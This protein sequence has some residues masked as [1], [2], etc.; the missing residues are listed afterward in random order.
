MKLNGKEKFLRTRI[1][2]KKTQLVTENNEG[3]N[4]FF[5]MRAST[6]NA[7]GNNIYLLFLKIINDDNKKEWDFKLIKGTVS[8]EKTKNIQIAWSKAKCTKLELNGK[9][10]KLDE[11]I[12]SLSLTDKFVFLTDNNK[13]VFVL[14][15]R[16]KKTKDTD[17]VINVTVFLQF[18]EAGEELKL[19]HV[20]SFTGWY[21]LF[22]LGGK[23]FK[24]PTDEPTANSEE[25]AVFNDGE[26]K[27]TKSDS[28]I[29][30]LWSFFKDKST[31]V[32]T[33]IGE[34]NNVLLFTQEKQE[35]TGKKKSF[36]FVD[37]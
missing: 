3:K 14:R 21:S 29:A 26:K 33:A 9:I 23:I 20:E 5:T 17:D 7:N 15:G 4:E 18:E 2:K 22:Q 19:S 13:I 8:S 34:N 24:T 12:T 10:K 30:S 35:I 27:F 11:R 36:F 37:V 1:K 25:V 6:V 28:P 31:F 16:F 32:T